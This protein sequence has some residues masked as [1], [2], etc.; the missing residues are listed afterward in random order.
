MRLST[1]LS[2]ALAFAALGASRAA[3]ADTGLGTVFVIAMENHNWTQ[4]STD[5]SAP[6][7]IFANPAAPFIN[8][9]V[10]PGNPNALQVSYAS[11]YLAA[12]LN[13]H[14]SEPNY[15]WAEAGTNY[16]AVT[17]T[18]I[19]N[20][21]DPSAAAG[22][23]FTQTPHLTGQMNAAGVAWKN[24]QED[25]QISSA[26]VPTGGNVLVSKSG[27]SSS[28]TNPY[29]HTNQYNYAA[30]HD[31]MAFFSDTATQ[32]VATFDSL[33][34]DIAADTISVSNPTAT[35]S[36]GKYNWITPNQYND[37]HSNLSTSF[38]YNGVSY[39]AGDAN[40]SI[41]LGDNFLAQ[42]VP[43][44]EN[45]Q[46]YKNNGAIVIWMDETEGTNRDDTH[47][48]LMEIVISPLAKGNAYVSTLE[49]NHSSDIKTMEEIFQLGGYI[50]NQLPPSEIFAGSTS[51][52]I[53][54]ANDLSD[55]FRNGVVPGAPAAVPE[56]ASL[57][58]LSLGSLL[59]LRRRR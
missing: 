43:E 44:I 31:P 42:V 13:E 45:T 46:A 14:P 47:H 58:V 35:S 53:A 32:N 51:N 22:N 15:L 29:Y 33:R 54:Y 5:T 2:L 12:G 20:D 27:T 3:L 28:V 23:M 21:A 38:T 7:Q 19:Q 18:L 39:T 6:P 59:L 41:A 8:S 1:S 50:N 40:Q 56:P 55:L 36:F 37:M 34:S 49:Y 52:Q 57:G 48:T 11:N 9:L 25:Y 30:K 26:A 10:T 24:Y 17:K 16:N 4:P